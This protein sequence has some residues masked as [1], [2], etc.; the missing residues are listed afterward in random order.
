MPKY[1]LS[2]KAFAALHEGELEPETVEKLWQL[3]RKIC[4][5]WG[6]VP[7]PETMKTRFLRFLSNRIKMNKAYVTHY[8][9]A[10][11][12]IDE[13]K[14]KLGV[15]GAYEHL[16]THPESNNPPHDSLLQQTRQLVSNEFISLQL[17]LGGFKAFT[18][19]INYPGYIAG[20]NGDGPPPYR[21]P[22]QP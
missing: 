16:F 21:T 19:A 12:V 18:G 20:W 11:R 6:N 8:R 22:S 1:D 5:R 7:E 17:S 2:E 3:F 15:D 9:T 13:L 4:E 10:V 14:Q